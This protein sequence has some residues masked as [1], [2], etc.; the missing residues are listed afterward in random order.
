VPHCATGT[1]YLYDIYIYDI[2]IY[3]IYIYMIYIYMIYIYMIYMVLS[4]HS[5]NLVLRLL[6][7]QSSHLVQI[8]EHLFSSG[9]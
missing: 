9:R 8:S 2:Y 5:K 6:D 4:V 1:I 7:P 3:D